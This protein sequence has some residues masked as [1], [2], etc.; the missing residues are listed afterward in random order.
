MCVVC[1]EVR[2]LATLYTQVTMDRGVSLVSPEVNFFILSGNRG[3][4]FRLV[5]VCVCVC[6]F[7]TFMC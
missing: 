5:S 2:I 7:F 1:N 3:I 6:V 4:I